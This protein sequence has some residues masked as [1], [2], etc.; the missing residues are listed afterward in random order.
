[1]VRVG[2]EIGEGQ[3]EEKTK[4]LEKQFPSSGG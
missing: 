1:M 4:D 3:K 2:A